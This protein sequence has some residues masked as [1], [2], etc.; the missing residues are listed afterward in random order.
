M[1][2]ARARAP[3]RVIP[4]APKPNANPAPAADATTPT[5]RM[6][7]VLQGLG[8]A[9]HAAEALARESGAA[10]PQ[11]LST[12]GDRSKGL[13]PK[14][15]APPRSA[16]AEGADELALLIAAVD[17]IARWLFWAHGEADIADA[18]KELRLAAKP[19]R[20]RM[21]PDRRPS[22]SGH[23]HRGVHPPTDRLA[24]LHDVAG[25]A[26]SAA[27]DADLPLPRTTARGRDR[28]AVLEHNAWNRCEPAELADAAYVVL[29]AHGERL[30]GAARP[31][32]VRKRLEREIA[33]VQNRSDSR[34][35]RVRHY[36]A[37]T[38]RA[39]GLK[40]IAAVNAVRTLD[41]GY[42]VSEE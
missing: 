26:L 21:R 4:L 24:L 33:S 9:V 42:R 15:A 3:A 36:V 32:D 5:A 14:R 22:T 29:R 7:A 25:A 37:A 10:T 41:D 31:G 18:V 11:V 35:Q 39:W 27:F 19:A 23:T 17:S 34:Q 2:A 20:E 16:I 30:L 1:K 8:D 40:K 12:L 13:S 38:L 6:L 28:T